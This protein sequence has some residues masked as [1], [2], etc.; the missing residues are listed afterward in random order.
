MSDPLELGSSPQ[1]FDIRLFYVSVWDT[2][3][4][5]F[6][7]CMTIY[8]EL[9]RASLDNSRHQPPGV[10]HSYQLTLSR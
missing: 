5:P 9:G 7:I 2:D 1:H 4:L 6:W 10:G 8:R 3:S